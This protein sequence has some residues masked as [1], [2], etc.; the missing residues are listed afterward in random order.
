M[1][2][3][4]AEGDVRDEGAWRS[5]DELKKSVGVQLIMK[6]SINHIVVRELE[7][8]SVLI[9]IMKNGGKDHSGDI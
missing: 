7:V 3:Q 6:L 8:E 2:L 4:E 1:K 5:V 9:K